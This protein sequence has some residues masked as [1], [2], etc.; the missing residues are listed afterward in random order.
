MNTAAFARH[1]RRAIEELPP[2]FRKKLENVEVVVEDFADDETLDEMGIETRYDLLGLYVG[3]PITERSVFDHGS[4]PDRIYLYRIPILR[5]A[6]G[7][8]D[9]ADAI[10]EVVI[11]EVGHHFGFDDD[12]LEEMTRRRGEHGQEP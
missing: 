11:H 1:V 4:L 2:D 10:R 7:M 9:I 3:V 5:E 6:R 12:Q 8:A